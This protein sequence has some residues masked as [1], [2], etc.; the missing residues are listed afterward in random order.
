VKVVDLEGKPIAGAAIRIVELTTTKSGTLD[1]FVKQW[2]ADKEKS[3][4]GPA[5]HLLTE[6]SFRSPEVLRQLSTATTGPDG[7]FRLTGIGRDRGLMLGVR[8]PGIADHYVRV[9]TRPGF[10]ASPGGQVA[11]SGPEPAVAVS[12][13]KPISGPVPDP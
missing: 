12:P 7:T 1:E 3:P 5:F 6:K 4:T 8:G 13:S 9:V 2:A 11:L 10:T